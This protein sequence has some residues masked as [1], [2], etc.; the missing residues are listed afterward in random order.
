MLAITPFRNRMVMCSFYIMTLHRTQI[1]LS[2]DDRRV[3]DAVSHRTGKSMSHLIR[4]A[5]HSTYGNAGQEDV[6]RRALAS[7]FGAV[8]SETSGE[9]LVESIR[10]GSRLRAHS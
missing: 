5:I 6:A 8:Q 10:S 3:L 1:S 9:E 4:Q 7:T 2:D